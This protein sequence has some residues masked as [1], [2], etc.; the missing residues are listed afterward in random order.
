MI[1]ND[2]NERELVVTV[3]LTAAEAAMVLHSIDAALAADKSKH[4]AALYKA[5]TDLLSA[6]GDKE[7]AEV[8]AEVSEARRMAYGAVNSGVHNSDRWAR[9]EG[10]CTGGGTVLEEV[11]EAS[12]K[13]EALLEQRGDNF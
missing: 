6:P 5:N 2:S 1:R 4:K 11:Q 10:T 9:R 12:E 13:I 7:F 8:C 3:N